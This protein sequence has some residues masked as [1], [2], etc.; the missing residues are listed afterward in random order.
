M[1]F[2]TILQSILEEVADLTSVNNHT[3]ARIYLCTELLEKFDLENK[4]EL[5]MIRGYYKIVERK[6]REEGH[7]NHGSYFKRGETDDRLYKFL[8]IEFSKDVASMIR[9]NL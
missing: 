5:H 9:S 3:D 2:M 7:L 6:Q 8:E 4:E 1:A